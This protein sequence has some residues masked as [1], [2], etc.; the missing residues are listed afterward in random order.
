MTAA[1][2]VAA[3]AIGAF[4]RALTGFGFALLAVPLLSL[5]L[6]LPSAVCLALLLQVAMV[7]RDVLTGAG[8]ID[9]RYLVLLLA[10][11]LPAV[12]VGQLVLLAIPADAARLILALLILVAILMRAGWRG[13]TV[14]MAR[15]PAPVTGIMAGLMAGLIAMPGPPVVL[16]ALSRGLEAERMRSTLVLFFG[17]L[18]VC[19]LPTMIAAGVIDR[20]LLLLALMALPLML[21]VDLIG[22][23]VAARIPQGLFERMTLGLL[24][25]S[26]AVAIGSAVRGW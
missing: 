16:H 12:P 20:E 9:R 10:G 6:D 15:A 1:F 25:L 14:L 23:T 13:F 22:R 24:V 4:A 7:P 3:I 18:S 11:A 8:R 19:G 5:T 21:L 2:V 17:A 26:A